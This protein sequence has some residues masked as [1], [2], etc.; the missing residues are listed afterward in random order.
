MGDDMSGIAGFLDLSARTPEPER[1]A[2]AMA[3]GGATWT[4]PAAGVAVGAAVLAASRDGRWVA[5]IDGTVLNAAELSARLAPCDG[6]SDAMVLAEA[7]ARWGLERGL[8]AA[9]GAFAAVLWDRV[10]RTLH[11]VR[12]RFGECMLAWGRFGGALLFASRLAA[13]R[14]HPAFTPE[15]DRDALAAMLAMGFV[16][17]SRCIHRHV[18]KLAPAEV[19][20][21]R[22]VDHVARPAWPVVERMRAVTG[23]FGGGPAAGAERLN[24]LLRGSVSAR[25]DAGRPVAVL[26]SGGPASSLVAAVARELGGRIHALTLADTEAAAAAGRAVATKLGVAHSEVAPPDAEGAEL[27]RRL[28]ALWDEPFA[29]PGQAG[30]VLLARAAAAGGDHVVLTGDG[31]DALFGGSPLYRQTAADWTSCQAA[32]P[33]RRRVAAWMARI[34]PGGASG[35][36]PRSAPALM[37]RRRALWRDLPPPVP[38][39]SRWEP[40]P[41]GLADPVQDCMGADLLCTLPDRACTL[42]RGAAD[43]AG[44]QILRPFLDPALA[45]FAWSLPVGMKIDAGLGEICLREVL[46]RYIP[47]LG[48]DPPPLGA[49]APLR[50]WLDGPLAEW[51]GDLLS[52]ERLRRQGL[53]DPRAPARCRAKGRVA[54]LWTLLMAQAWIDAASP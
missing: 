10:E 20:S 23:G 49:G 13:L 14:R 19:L 6:S 7:V 5:A 45:E 53:V 22:G 34:R 18:H 4:D 37:A 26:V 35:S 21:V 25:L 42:G 28:P 46:W 52:E 2:A 47:G 3:G 15:I 11:L 51:A 17:S 43:A 29:H 16:P 41:A 38:G 30:A 50:A 44:I 31:A 27:L 54:E 12:D 39:A 9:D 40:A 36:P 48:E 1:T 33:W 24:L 8:Q 32:A